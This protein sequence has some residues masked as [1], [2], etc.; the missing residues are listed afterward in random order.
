[1]PIDNLPPLREVI[2]IYGLQAHK[3]LGQ[4]FL[5]TLI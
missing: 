4:N 3:S 2:D 1:M 5:L